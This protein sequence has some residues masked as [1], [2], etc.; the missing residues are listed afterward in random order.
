MD[1]KE[2]RDNIPYVSPVEPRELTLDSRF[3]FRCHKDITCF[4]ACCRNIDITLTPYDI[5]RLKRRLAMRSKDFVARYTIPFEMDADGMPGLKLIT[6]PGTSEC[7]FLGEGGCTVYGDRP[8]ACRYY[9]LGNMAVRKKD[10]LNVEE[11]YFVV[12]ESH[13]LGHEEEQVQSVAEYRHEQGIDDYDEMNREWRNIVL[14]KRSS[15]PAIGKPSERSLQLFDMCS[16]DMDSFRE[17][18]ASDG[19]RSMF[20]IDDAGCTHLAADEDALLAFSM[21]F[22]KQVLFG[23]MSIPVR[24]NA[25]EERISRRKEV[26]EQRRVEEVVRRRTSE[27]ELKYE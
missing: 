2:I 8:A 11:V 21:R 24:E 4:N 10:S 7:T 13:C 27:E 25:R 26:W 22:L 6:K 18:I 1:S 3:R 20:E 14:K 12:R 23:E 19:F 15:G 17:F 9:A 16:Y 5:L